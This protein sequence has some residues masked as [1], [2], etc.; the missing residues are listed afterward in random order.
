MELRA[1]GGRWRLGG[2]GLQE[3]GWGLD[4]GHFLGRWEAGVQWGRE[5]GRLQAEYV[6]WE[7]GTSVI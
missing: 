1:T 7:E 5:K 6:A 4:E 3:E 2:L